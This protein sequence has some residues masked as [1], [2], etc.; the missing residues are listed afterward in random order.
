MQ[1]IPI[2]DSGKWEFWFDIE[3]W[4]RPEF[5]SICR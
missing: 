2:I 4:F 5:D 1:T 3:W